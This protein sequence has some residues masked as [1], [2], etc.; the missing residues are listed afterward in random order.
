MTKEEL[1]N[2]IRFSLPNADLLRVV[3]FAGVLIN[4]RVFAIKVR[5]SFDHTAYMGQLIE[6]NK[7][8]HAEHNIKELEKKNVIFGIDVLNRRGKDAILKLEE[9]MK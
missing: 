7:P 2:E 1:I 9:I 8:Y 3:N 6:Y 4:G 5:P